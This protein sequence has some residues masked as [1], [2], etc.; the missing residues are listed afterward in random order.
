M[1]DEKSTKPATKTVDK[2]AQF[3]TL[4]EAR[5]QSILDRIAVLTKL[6]RPRDYTYSEA[7]VAA[8]EAALNGAV[9]ESMQEF[10][11][12]GTKKVKGFSIS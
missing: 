7:D 10:R 8:I 3:V 5:V 11:K 4:A 1:A 6:A 12:P 9:A 2:R